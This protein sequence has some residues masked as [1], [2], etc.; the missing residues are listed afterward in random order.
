MA[1]NK[2][3][4]EDAQALRTEQ[5]RRKA[6]ARQDRARELDRFIQ[7]AMTVN[8]PANQIAYPRARWTDFG[9]AA[10]QTIPTGQW[11]ILT[12]STWSG[13][14]IDPQP[15]PEPEPDCMLEYDDL[16]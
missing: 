10:R 5:R 3:I 16:E 13:F 6:Q 11:Q 14:S 4:A 9:I 8:A 2:L 1:G 7:D 15:P 12:T